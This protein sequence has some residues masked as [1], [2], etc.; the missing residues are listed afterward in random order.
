M[1]GRTIYIPLSH[2]PLAC[3][4]VLDSQLQNPSVQLWAK[5]TGANQLVAYQCAHAATGC[6][7]NIYGPIY[8]LILFY[9]SQV[10]TQITFQ[11]MCTFF[12]YHYLKKPFSQAGENGLPRQMPAPPA[13]QHLRRSTRSG[14]PPGKIIFPA[15]QS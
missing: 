4:L 15:D 1:L 10:Q 14:G 6:E 7:R 11:S 2:S 8:Q 3:I 13:P 5:N 9:Y 12:N